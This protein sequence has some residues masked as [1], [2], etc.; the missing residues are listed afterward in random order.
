MNSD[1]YK[2][3]IKKT[4]YLRFKMSYL[5]NAIGDCSEEV[6]KCIDDVWDEIKE[7]EKKKSPK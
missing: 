1:K 4:L 3:A 5:V 2:P 7:L 6:K